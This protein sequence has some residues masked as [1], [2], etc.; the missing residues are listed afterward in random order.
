MSMVLGM[1]CVESYYK[2]K[3]MVMLWTWFANV[4]TIFKIRFLV[5]FLGNHLSRDYVYRGYSSELL[6]VTLLRVLRLSTPMYPVAPFCCQALFS[7]HPF[8]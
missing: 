4:I 7:L 5:V 6:A 1:D 2:G 3:L 8:L